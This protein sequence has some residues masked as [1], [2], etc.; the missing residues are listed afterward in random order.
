V[1]Q[2][3]GHQFETDDRVRRCEEGVKVC[4]LRSINNIASID[5]HLLLLNK[6]SESCRQILQN[7]Q[8]YPKCRNVHRLQLSI[9]LQKL[10]I[11]IELEIFRQYSGG[12]YHIDRHLN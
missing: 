4:H 7:A 8:L 10:L 3:Q 12:F 5:N 9:S 11:Y 2:A 6:I 1:R